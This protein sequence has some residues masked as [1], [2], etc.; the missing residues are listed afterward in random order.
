MKKG[1]KG[2]EI[3]NLTKNGDREKKIHVCFKKMVKTGSSR[4]ELVFRHFEVKFNK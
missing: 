4:W 2:K 1:R 3:G